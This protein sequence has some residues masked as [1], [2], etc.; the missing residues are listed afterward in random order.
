MKKLL[1]SLATVMMFQSPLVFAW[2]QPEKAP[3]LNS[4]FDFFN[5]PAS[6]TTL[7]QKAGAVALSG[8]ML[9]E[10]GDK[11]LGGVALGSIA[12]LGKMVIDNNNNLSHQYEEELL[13]N[14]GQEEANL[15][16]AKL[17]TM[18]FSENQTSGPGYLIFAKNIGIGEEFA[19]AQMDFENTDD[20]QQNLTLLKNYFNKFEQNPDWQEDY[21]T[22]RYKR[23]IVFYAQNAKQYPALDESTRNFITQLSRLKREYDFL[24]NPDNGY[25]TTQQKE[26]I[27]QVF[28]CQNPNYRKMI[29]DNLFLT[30]AKFEASYS[31]TL[32]ADEIWYKSGSL[33]KEQY[34]KNIGNNQFDMNSYSKL[35]YL[36]IKNDSMEDDHIPSFGAL[37]EFMTNH[38]YSISNSDK[39][40][41]K[42]AS[43]IAV[44][45]LL[46]QHGR[47]W[48]SK[49][50]SN[51]ISLDASDLKLATLKDFNT[52]IERMK[53]KTIFNGVN[54]YKTNDFDNVAKSISILYERNKLLCLYD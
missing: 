27:K 43:A 29:Y 30:P 9:S 35:E 3:D 39:T 8:A 46:H 47:S 25:L 7:T 24:N 54:E 31:Y 40:L 20:Y 53:D 49:N 17:Q 10:S 33:K 51:L 21:A 11:V 1:L 42:N 38:G 50:D 23:F 41:R 14:P 48:G 36:R 16:L 18:K 12:L 45:K 52:Y 6:K 22:F 13:D 37:K 32:V 44:L 34:Q 15:I 19:Q 28:S 5:N 4:T 26:K 2:G